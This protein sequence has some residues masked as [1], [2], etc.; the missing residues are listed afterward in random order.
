M[1]EIVEEATGQGGDGD[2]LG[3]EGEGGLGGIGVA[4]EVVYAGRLQEVSPSLSP[5]P[6][7]PLGQCKKRLEMG[8][9]WREWEFMK[10]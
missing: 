7:P 6:S 9:G 3:E 10:N 8:R 1:A 4:V 2:G 5:P